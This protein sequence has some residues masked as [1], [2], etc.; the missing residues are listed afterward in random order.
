MYSE[1][2][3]SNYSHPLCLGHQEPGEGRAGRERHESVLQHP[4]GWLPELGGGR[5]R[6]PARHQLPDHQACEEVGGLLQP[7]V[8]Q[9]GLPL[10]QGALPPG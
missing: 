5:G 2:I 3:F 6:A 4:A 1:S 9:P 8:R 10:T 7:H